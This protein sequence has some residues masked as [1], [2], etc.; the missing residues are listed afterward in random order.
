MPRLFCYSIMIGYIYKTTNLINNKIYIGKHLS[1]SY[2]SKYYGSGVLLI[3]A[4]EKYGIDNF[5]NEIIDIAETE[6]ELNKKEFEYINQYKS[7]YGRNCYNIASGGT[8]GNTLQYAS[9]EKYNNFIE[10]MSIINKNRCSSNEFK[11]KT[12]KRMKKLYENEVEREK[13]RQKQYIFWKN[14]QEAHKR[15]SE[16]VTEMHKRYK[17]KW[18]NGKAI[19]CIMIF[20]HTA[21]NFNYLSEF[22]EFVKMNYN[23]HP[24]RNIIKRMFNNSLNLIPYKS[25]H[26]SRNQ[27]DG[28]FLFKKK[29][30]KTIITKFQGVSTNGDECSQVGE[31]LSLLQMQDN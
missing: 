4:I 25:F 28:M 17:G 29:D 21:Y 14:N 16:I 19:P 5:K 8:G 24:G 23:L 13:Q 10:K 9:K 11:E 2:D 31:I 12:S 30:I 26:K 20:N 7:E 15:Q 1:N 27:L 22:L 6:E 3:K 18:N